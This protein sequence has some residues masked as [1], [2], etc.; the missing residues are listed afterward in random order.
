MI[1]GLTSLVAWPAG[2]TA[3]V[4]LDKLTVLLIL[5]D[6][7]GVGTGR[8]LCRNEETGAPVFGSPPV[9]ISF[10]GKD[11]TGHYAVTVKLLDCRFPAPGAYVVQFLFEDALV[12]EQPI[13]VR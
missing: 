5:T 2:T 3:P 13:T 11:P 10:E 12:R 8:I 4:R 6:G 1:V 7:R 9:R